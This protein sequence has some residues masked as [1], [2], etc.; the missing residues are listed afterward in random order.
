LV[1]GQYAEL[2]IV[3]TFTYVD[4]YIIQQFRVRFQNEGPPATGIVAVFTPGPEEDTLSAI[5]YLNAADPVSQHKV[6]EPADGW[7]VAEGEWL[8]FLNFLAARL[9]SVCIV[10]AG[11]SIKVSYLASEDGNI[12]IDLVALEDAPSVA[13]TFNFVKPLKEKK[14]ASVRTETLMYKLDND[15]SSGGG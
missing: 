8:F 5:H 4:I 3:H 6:L 9:N 7:F 2:F 13:F 11:Q 15:I 1:A 14:K 10:V 12:V